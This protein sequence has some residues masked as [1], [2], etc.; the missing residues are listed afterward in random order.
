MNTYDNRNLVK[1]IEKLGFD[2]LSQIVAID[3]TSDSKSKT[4]PSTQ[5]QF[6]V[7][8]FIVDFFQSLGIG[9]RCDEMANVV[10]YIDGSGMGASQNPIAFITHIDNVKGTRPSPLYISKQWNGFDHIPYPKNGHIEVNVENFP[11][12][13]KFLNQNIVFGNGDYPFGLD[14]KLGV[15]ETML[16]AYLL[17]TQDE[18]VSHPPI[19]FVFRPDE[20]IASLKTTQK[21]C[22][23]LSKNNVQYAYTIDGS[24]PFEINTKNFNASYIS[25]KFPKKCEKTFSRNGYIIDFEI[26]GVN[27]H[28]CSAYEEGYYSDI[29]IMCDI[30]NELGIGDHKYLNY[31]LL[32]YV[33]HE[34][35][36]TSGIGQIYVQQEI[37]AECIVAIIENM[38]KPHIKMGA[39]YNLSCTYFQ[40]KTIEIDYGIQKLFDWLTP[41]V[42]NNLQLPSQSQGLDGYANPNKITCHE[43]HWQILIQFRDFEMDELS[44]RVQMVA[45]DLIANEIDF[46]YGLRYKKSERFFKL[47]KLM[48]DIPILAA[49]EIGEKANTIPMR[50]STLADSFLERGIS[51]ANLGTGYFA[52]ESA[53]EL[54][55]LE[56]IS[57][58][59]FWLLHICT[60]FIF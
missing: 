36:A 27:T 26:N 31:S 45:C 44:K 38:I 53:K 16:L 32:S 43:N 56:M 60:K 35:N 4:I 7:S 9:A 52:P 54:T 12:L 49:Q 11:T 17:K 42:L 41:M 2:L 21:I 6:N 59:S 3:S 13:K 51:V 39:S 46:S 30:L 57:K 47:P 24:E 37:D 34:E 19:F 58:H 25:V 55:S 5:H 33:S 23:L 50:A 48:V 14:D 40:D 20:E 10:A 1:R 15:V 28:T 22:E 29:M 18:Q 8:H